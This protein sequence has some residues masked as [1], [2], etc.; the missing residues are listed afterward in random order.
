MRSIVISYRCVHLLLP[1]IPLAIRSRNPHYSSVYLCS[2]VDWRG[3][4]SPR[5]EQLGLLQDGSSNDRS[6][7]DRLSEGGSPQGWDSNGR[8]H[9]GCSNLSGRACKRLLSVKLSSA[10]C[11]ATGDQSSVQFS[12]MIHV[13]I[14]CAAAACF[15]ALAWRYP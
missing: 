9:F 3:S 6:A 12:V 2:S 14:I 1:V 4:E 8:I 10:S 13:I 5:S 15:K 11:D 7:Q